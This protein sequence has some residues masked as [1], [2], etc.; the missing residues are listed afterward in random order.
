M[1]CGDAIKVNKKAF[2]QRAFEGFSIM[3]Y[4]LD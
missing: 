2:K 1:P 3:K 4:Y